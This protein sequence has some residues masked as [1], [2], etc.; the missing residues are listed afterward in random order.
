MKRIQLLDCTLRDGA[1]VVEGKFGERSIAGIIKRLQDVKVDIIE[2][3]WLKD[4]PHEVG[5]TYYYT[6]DDLKQYMQMKK[7]KYSTYVA[8]IDYNR[9]DVNRLPVCDGE[10]ID[11]IRI[12][13]PKDKIE[14]GLSL[15]EPIRKKGYKVFLQ[16]ANTVGYSDWELLSLVEAVN[17]VDVEALSIV[18]TYG[19]MYDFDLQRILF[20]L[21]NNLR[22]DISIGF[23][24]H[25]NQQLSYALSMQFV[26]DI[27]ALTGR[28]CIV[29][30]SLCGMGRGAG[31]TPTELLA[32][33]LN[34][35]YYADYDIN[36]LMDAIDIYMSHFL[37]KYRWGYSI[38]Y[39]IA[40]T[41][42]CHVNNVAYLTKTH[43]TKSKD[44]KI[45]FEML[46]AD[47]RHKYDYDN[48]EKVYAEYQN[49][50]ADDMEV[51]DLLIKQMSGKNLVIILPGKSSETYKEKIKSYIRESG[52]IV[53]GV[54]AIVTDYE[55]DYLFFSN[56][57]KYEFAKDTNTVQYKEAIKIITSNIKDCGNEKEYIINYNNLQKRKWKYYDNSVIMFL[58]LM[59]VILPKTIAIAGFD[60]YAD[61]N[62]EKYAEGILEPTISQEEMNVMQE[63]IADMFADYV[64]INGEKIKIEFLTP[65]IFEELNK[66]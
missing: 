49:R 31:N 32:G 59:S 37:E 24:S 14:E 20:L 12:V 64:K 33:Y 52:A 53:I 1:Y 9:Y 30:S 44:M 50:N 40:G 46:T 61:N 17:E 41:Y 57:I 15:V 28:K 3:G 10:T 36:T 54:N 38:P 2:C 62:S 21:N 45:I 11:A 60:G 63:E 35:Q 43:R 29:D 34:K 25:N 58:R 51:K 47:E 56:G 23:H 16:A 66:F 13:F 18:D 7:S 65:S 4:I 27:V 22:K 26:D 48:L 39:M 42:E 19:T 6:P 55:Y 8:M 5:T